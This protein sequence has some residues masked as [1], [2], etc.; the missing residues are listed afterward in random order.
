LPNELIK[1]KSSSL[2]IKDTLSCEELFSKNKM[3][4]NLR[5]II[6]DCKKNGNEE[7]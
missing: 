7:P 1:E 3:K 5:E 6:D 2:K 4:K